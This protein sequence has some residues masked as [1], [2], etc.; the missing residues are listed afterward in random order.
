MFC[1]G[2]GFV[3][4]L[5]CGCVDDADGVFDADNEGLSDNFNDEGGFFGIVDICAETGVGVEFFTGSFGG[6]ETD[7]FDALACGS[8]LDF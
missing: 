6:K 2:G 3:D 7:A 1:C 5:V 8:G 4:G